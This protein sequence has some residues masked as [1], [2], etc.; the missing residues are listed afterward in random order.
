MRTI[1]TTISVIF[2]I[3]LSI[4][5]QEVPEWFTQNMEKSIGTW[6]TNN[7]VY[8][9]QNEPFDQYE[10]EWVWGVGKQSITGKLY[11]II[12]GKRQGLFWEFRQY[13][14]VKKHQA[15]V[16]QYG[17]DGTIGIGAMIMKKGQVFELTQAFVSTKGETTIHG[18]RSTFEKSKLITTSYN[19]SEKGKWKKDRTYEWNNIQKP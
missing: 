15:M 19:I 10:M 7:D 18:H 1:I 8:K 3:N 2:F 11:G 14:D 13:W 6:I 9:N 16:V 17:G 12:A 4:A 5:Q